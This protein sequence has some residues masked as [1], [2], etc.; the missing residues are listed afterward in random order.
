[1]GE[2][3]GRQAQE[4]QQ[5]EEHTTE[6]CCGSLEGHFSPGDIA[7]NPE[8]PT[9][10]MDEQWGVNTEGGPREAPRVQPVNIPS[11]A[12]YRNVTPNV[13]PASAMELQTFLDKCFLGTSKQI[14]RQRHKTRPPE[15]DGRAV[16]MG[17]ES[18]ASHMMSAVG[19]EAAGSTIRC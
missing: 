6:P 9:L 18:L 19:I 1:M 15:V 16:G 5:A 2:V 14:V 17:D 3:Y 7:V 8:Q 11:L 4:R 13:R 10:L 12:I